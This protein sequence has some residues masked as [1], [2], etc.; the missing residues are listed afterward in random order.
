MPFFSGLDLG[1]TADYTALAVVEQHTSPDGVHCY[2]CRLLERWKLGTPYPVIVRDVVNK[3]SR[4]PLRDSIL[5]VDN[6]GVGRAVMDVFRQQPDLLA[7]LIPV[8]IVNAFAPNRQKGEWHVPKKDLVGV[9]QVLFGSKDRTGT[10]KRLWIAPALKEAKTL[11]REI[12]TFRVK[13][14][15]NTGH[16]SFEHWRA[17]DHDDLVLALSMPLWYAERAGRDPRIG[18]FRVIGGGHPTFA[19]R[20]DKGIK[21]WIMS[22]EEYDARAMQEKHLLVS[23]GN[24]GES[25]NRPESANLLDSVRVEFIDTTPKESEADWEQIKEPYGK[26]TKELLMAGTH[27]KQIWNMLLRKRGK[28]PEVIVVQDDGKDDRRGES[29]AMAVMDVLGRPRGMIWTP[30]DPERKH[31]GEPQNE[32]VFAITK[33]GRGMVCG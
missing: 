32:H 20:S 31:D 13:V 33:L 4:H 3:F 27:G 19:P 1:Q 18:Q 2:D 6:T 5:C 8:T 12:A 15:K 16:E 24:P 7:K 17:R 21:T 11:E 28:I 9:L 22:R 25:W 10:R 26:L 14:N 23:I 29:V 30:R